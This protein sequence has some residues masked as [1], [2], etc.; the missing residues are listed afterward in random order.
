MAE[1]RAELARRG[2]V[3]HSPTIMK[4]GTA[5]GLAAL[6]EDPAKLLERPDESWAEAFHADVA[7]D[8]RAQNLTRSPD[9][10]FAAVRDGARTVAVGVVT[11]GHGWA[12]VHGMRT[13]PD[14]RK[15]GHARRILSAFGRA[16]AA[17]GV[18]R[19]ALQVTEDNPARGLY[20][21]AGFTLAWRYRY[22]TE[23]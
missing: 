8:R 20:R 13:A 10:L 19:F 9:A 6:S 17:R 14:Q 16:A 3:A 22:W 2:Y 4:L 11:F 5:A 12:G 15:R 23:G 1:T 21:G 7:G 18:E